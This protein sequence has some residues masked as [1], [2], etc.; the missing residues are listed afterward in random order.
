MATLLFHYIDRK[1]QHSHGTVKNITLEK[2]FEML[3]Q[4]VCQGYQLIYA[5]WNDQASAPITL[6]VD[7]FDGESM[8]E[9]L[10]A[11]QRQWEHILLQP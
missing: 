7:A 8:T 1:G 3:N 4:F 6:P 11:L 10:A 2:S 5:Q 9:P